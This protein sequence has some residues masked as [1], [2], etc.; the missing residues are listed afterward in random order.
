MEGKPVKLEVFIGVRGTGS[1][2]KEMKLGKQSEDILS[3]VSNK[4]TNV[5][6]TGYH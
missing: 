6:M 5:I 1:V 4:L 2:N 3:C